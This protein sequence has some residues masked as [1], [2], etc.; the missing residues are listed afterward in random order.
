MEKLWNF[1]SGDL[2]KPWV[3]KGDWGR[4]YFF[5]SYFIH[6]IIGISNDV[7]KDDKITINLNLSICHY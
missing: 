4:F 7:V 3:R 6:S 1:F 5:L 2:Y